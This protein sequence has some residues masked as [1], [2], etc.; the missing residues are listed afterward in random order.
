MPLTAS[1]PIRIRSGDYERATQISR[2]T[3][4]SRVDAIGVALES[5]EHVPAKKREQLID[6][7]HN[8][9][10]EHDGREKAG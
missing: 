3:R 2:K 10:V 6:R 4:L 5:F 1:K 8:T 7:R 9:V